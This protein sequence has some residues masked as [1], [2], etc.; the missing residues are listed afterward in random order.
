[1]ERACGVEIERVSDMD[2]TRIQI[3]LTLFEGAL[4]LP[5]PRGAGGI[6][7]AGVSGD[8]ELLRSLE[9]LLDAR[10][11]AENFFDIDPLS[12]SSEKSLPAPMPERRTCR[13]NPIDWKEATRASAAT[14][15]RAHGR[16]RLRCG[17]SRRAEEPVRRQ[18]ALK[19]IRLGMDTERVIARFEMERQA[20]AL[21]NHPNIA[22]V[23]DAGATEA[24]RSY[25]VMELVPGRADH[26]LLRPASARHPE[27]AGAFHR[28]LPG[29]PARAPEGHPAPRH[30]ALEHPRRGAW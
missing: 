22:Q 8:P 23:L 10:A 17:V 4:N 6:S 1:M 24:G 11:R 12:G 2:D 5:D 25:F 29:D 21:M 9:S 18:V 19:I 13:P 20:L 14:A 27:P 3:Q 15:C 30:Q 26:G 28:G 7:R 16:R